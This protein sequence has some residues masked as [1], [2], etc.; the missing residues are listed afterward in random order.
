MADINVIIFGNAFWYEIDG[1]VKLIVAKSVYS[2][3]LSYIKE[4]A[5][6]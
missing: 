2:L 5:L 3:V 6:F 4:T 1:A